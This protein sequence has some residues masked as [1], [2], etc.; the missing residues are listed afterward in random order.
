MSGLSFADDASASEI[1]IMTPTSFPGGPVTQE[2]GTKALKPSIF[3]VAAKEC[4]VSVSERIAM[5]TSYFTRSK[6][7]CLILPLHFIPRTLIVNTLSLLVSFRAFS[8]V[9]FLSLVR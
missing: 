1:R 6:R 4:V 2:G 5:E 7:I 9:D 3:V 8:L